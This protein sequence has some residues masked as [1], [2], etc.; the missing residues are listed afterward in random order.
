MRTG[1]LRFALALLFACATGCATT[2]NTTKQPTSTTAKAA[3][4]RSKI[5]VLPVESDNFPKA[6][7]ALNLALDQAAF[8]GPKLDIVRPKASLE[9]IQLS[10]ECVEATTNCYAAVGRS[11]GAEHVVLSQLQGGTKRRDKQVKIALTL[12]DTKRSE[13]V[14]VASETFA[15]ENAAERGIAMLV[16]KARAATE[17]LPVP[18]GAQ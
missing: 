12:F 11:L 14:E 17:R 15:D 16:E 8:G 1:A 9:V 2:S 6:A 4:A 10:I 13:P 5:A 3:P 18:G 7:R